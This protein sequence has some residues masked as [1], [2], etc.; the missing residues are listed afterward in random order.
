MPKQLQR[1]RD[2]DK[3]AVKLARKTGEKQRQQQRQENRERKYN[4]YEAE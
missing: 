3:L 1:F 2:N 4:P